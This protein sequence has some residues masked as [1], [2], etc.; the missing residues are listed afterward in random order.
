MADST[1]IG[2]YHGLSERVDPVAAWRYATVKRCPITGDAV[3]SGSQ[4]FCVHSAL[5]PE[6]VCTKIGR[7]VQFCSLAADYETFYVEHQTHSV[8]DWECTC[9]YYAIKRPSPVEYNCWIAVYCQLAGLT[10]EAELGY[11]ARYVRMRGLFVPD[12]YP[13]HERAMVEGIAKRLD[14][15]VAA[16]GEAGSLLYYLGVSDVEPDQITAYLPMDYGD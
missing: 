2:P 6:A 4:G 8:P 16:P 9:G 11:R 1:T 7:P 14:V 15:P 3:L 13:V 12:G 5:L 10:V